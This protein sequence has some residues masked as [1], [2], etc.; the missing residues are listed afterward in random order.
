MKF[1]VEENSSK[2]EVK[3]TFPE[4]QKLSEFVIVNCTKKNTNEYTSRRRKLFL[5]R[6]TKMQNEKTVLQRG[7]RMMLIERIV[8]TSCEI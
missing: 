1:C 8:I 4:E 5:E 3:E 2:I 7:N 6:S